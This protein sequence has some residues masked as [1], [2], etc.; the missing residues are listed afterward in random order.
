MIG[1][2]TGSVFGN[3]YGANYDLGIQHPE[4]QEPLVY[5][6]HAEGKGGDIVPQS[7]LPEDAILQDWDARVQS[8]DNLISANIR[9][10]LN[11]CAPLSQ[12]YSNILGDSNPIN[13]IDIENPDFEDVEIIN[14]CLW[15]IGNHVGMEIRS[16]GEDVD[17]S[18]KR[19]TLNS[20]QKAME[21]MHE[22][23]DSPEYS[24]MNAVYQQMREMEFEYS[25]I[26]NTVTPAA[27]EANTMNQN[28]PQPT[29]FDFQ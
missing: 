26:K 9:E 4:T 11:T 6:A 14:G 10:P 16:A 24:D 8:A 1:W 3:E 20:I 25:E 28:V 21:Q 5:R 18:A 19:E 12:S 23:I 2:L 17:V 29:T 27:E 7:D 22:I 13:M 15:D